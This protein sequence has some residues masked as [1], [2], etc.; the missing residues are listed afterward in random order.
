MTKKQKE[1]DD[2]TACM[3]QWRF[4]VWKQKMSAISDHCIIQSTTAGKP[5][6]QKYG[7]CDSG[8]VFV[9][10]PAKVLKRQLVVQ[11]NAL[12]TLESGDWN[13]LLAIQQAS[14]CGSIFWST[15]QRA[16]LQSN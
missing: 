2:W 8:Q 3:C 14:S 11:E 12:L 5:I 7:G 13:E 15:E 6:S 16:P 10:W 9:F 1:T 4:E